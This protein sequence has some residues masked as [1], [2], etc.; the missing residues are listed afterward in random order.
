MVDDRLLLAPEAVIAEYGFEYLRWN[1]RGSSRHLSLTKIT[2][3]C[4]I[5]PQAHR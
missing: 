4:G 5:L 1:G 3:E 2:D